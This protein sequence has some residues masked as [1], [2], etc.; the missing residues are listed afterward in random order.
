[1]IG[2]GPSLNK[3]MNITQELKVSVDTCWVGEDDPGYLV[4]ENVDS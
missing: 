4:A 1:M 3:G 2:N